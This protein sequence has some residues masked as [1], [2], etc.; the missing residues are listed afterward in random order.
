MIA[1]LCLIAPAAQASAVLERLGQAGL[2]LP[3]FPA[4]AA[5][6]LPPAPTADSTLV[7]IN[8]GNMAAY[9]QHLAVA[10]QGGWRLL[11]L[12]V[13]LHNPFGKTMGWMVAAGGNHD[14]FALATPVL[15]ALA[16]PFPKAWLHAGGPGAGAFLNS[17]ASGWLAQ[18]ES[19]WQWLLH[20]LQQPGASSFDLQSWQ[21]LIDH[22]LTHLQ[23]DARSYLAIDTG[24]FQPWFAD[25]CA[26][27]L[28]PLTRESPARQLANWFLAAQAVNPKP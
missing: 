17:I 23:D 19:V 8:P 16:P 11:D 15:D 12:A 18:S 25:Q 27:L 14:D 9:Q 28:N 2:G 26:L 13:N 24:P 1:Q 22:S 3:V 21:T 6:A 7:L 20:A 5:A 4:E 10:R